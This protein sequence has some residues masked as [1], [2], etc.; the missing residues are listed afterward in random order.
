MAYTN[1]NCRL[2]CNSLI[3]N[4]MSGGPNGLDPFSDLNS[5]LD[6]YASQCT[7][8]N[9]EVCDSRIGSSNYDIGH[10]FTT[11]AG[12]FSQVGIV[13]MNG[14][15]AQSVTGELHPTGDAFDIDYVA[16]EMGHEF[17]AN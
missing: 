4:V 12:G 2:R 13:C 7:M 8:R 9:Q 17:G 14:V 5:T 3:R 15:K 1:A 6:S 10:V 16:H 11:G